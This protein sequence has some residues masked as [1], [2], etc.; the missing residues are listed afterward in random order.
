MCKPPSKEGDKRSVKVK[1]NCGDQ[2]ATNIY[3][4]SGVDANGTISYTQG[5][6]ADLQ[7]GIK[8]MVI[9]ETTGLWFMN[10]TFGM[11]LNAT[12]ILVWPQ[13]RTTTG[14]QAFTVSGNTK[15]SFNDPPDDD[16]DY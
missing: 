10:R 16:M 2:R 8:A 15:L 6:H 9:V 4:V 11:S 1:V 7:K 14:I 5:S 3:V 13:R 12:E